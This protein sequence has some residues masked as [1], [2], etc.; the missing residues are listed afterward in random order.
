MQLPEGHPVYDA[1]GDLWTKEDGKWV[2]NDARLLPESLIH[3][4]GPIT[5]EEQ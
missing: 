1:T 5:L 3:V 4:W 2:C